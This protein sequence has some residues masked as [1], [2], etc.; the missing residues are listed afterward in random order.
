MEP[1][2]SIR[3]PPGTEAT[4]TCELPNV[5]VGGSRAAPWRA[6]AAAIFRKT[7]MREDA[8]VK[9]ALLSKK[10]CEAEHGAAHEEFVRVIE[11]GEVES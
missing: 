1:V 3:A 10:I 2:L 5:T 8:E 6:S 7:R 4:E 11:A 9:R